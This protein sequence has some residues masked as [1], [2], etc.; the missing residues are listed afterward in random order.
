MK[1]FS[2]LTNGYERNDNINLK[3]AILGAP[4]SGKSTLSSGLLYFSKLFLFNADAVPEVAK[5]DYYKGEDFTSKNYEYEKNFTFCSN[6]FCIWSF[7]YKRSNYD[8]GC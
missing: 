4:G 5:W 7:Y 2:H 6:A 1:S 8:N 3:I